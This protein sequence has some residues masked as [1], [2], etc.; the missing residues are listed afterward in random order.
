MEVFVS[1]APGGPYLEFNLA[2]GGQWAAYRFSGYREDMAPLTA[3]HPPR[4]KL[5]TQPH[6]LLL[7]ADITL[8]AD[9]AAAGL[10]LAIAAVVENTQGQLSYWALRHG[11]ERPDFHHPDGFQLEI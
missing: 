3:S 2:P 8:P 4:M 10:Q 7:R 1:P 11:G 6:A 5:R 9:L